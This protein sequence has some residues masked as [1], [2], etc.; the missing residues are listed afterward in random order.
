VAGL[1]ELLGL[2]LHT[3]VG[4]GQ[5]G[6]SAD[7]RLDLGTR[8]GLA[9]NAPLVGLDDFDGGL[10]DR[11]GRGGGGGGVKSEPEDLAGVLSIEQFG[12]ISHVFWVCQS[13]GRLK[14]VRTE[15]T[16]FSQMVLK[17]IQKWLC[18]IYS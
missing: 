6:E 7:A 14:Y 11:H 16:L 13:R 18:R 3:L 12:D 2:G 17:Q 10:V 4:F 15:I 1:R 5:L 8:L 9:G